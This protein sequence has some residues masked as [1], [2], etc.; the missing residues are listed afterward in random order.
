MHEDA[1]AKIKVT[2][3]NEQ[4]SQKKKKPIE[5]ESVDNESDILTQMRQIKQ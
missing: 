1:S 5:S 4:Q 2:Q 3:K